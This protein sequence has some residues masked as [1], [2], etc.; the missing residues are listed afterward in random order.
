MPIQPDPPEHSSH[1]VG[2]VK[3]T[4]TSPDLRGLLAKETN[5]RRRKL[6]QV[7]IALESNT[8]PNDIA[9]ETGISRASVYRHKSLLAAEGINRFL[10]TRPGRKPQFRPAREHIQ[11]IVTLSLSSM[12]LYN[13]TYLKLILDSHGHKHSAKTIREWLS[14]AKRKLLPERA[15][16]RR[17]R[18]TKAGMVRAHQAVCEGTCNFHIHRI[19]DMALAVLPWPEDKNRPLDDLLREL[20]GRPSVFM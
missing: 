12:V 5:P 3:S 6:L 13:P 7:A 8:H 10:L 18:A 4:S 20:L 11:S 15:A 16:I 2:A 14:A 1:N 17:I 9:L 19:A